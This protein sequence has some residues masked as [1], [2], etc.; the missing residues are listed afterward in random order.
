MKNFLQLLSLGI[1]LSIAI[2]WLNSNDNNVEETQNNL[3][4]VRYF[5]PNGNN[6]LQLSEM[7]SNLEYIPINFQDKTIGKVVTTDDRIFVSNFV[8]DNSLTIYDRK[9]E[10]LVK[11]NGSSGLNLALPVDF[12]VDEI[13]Q[14]I[15]I[16]DTEQKKIFKFDYEGRLVHEFNFGIHFSAFNYSTKEEKFILYVPMPFPGTDLDGNS[17]VIFDQNLNITNSHFPLHDLCQEF[18]P[19]VSNRFVTSG[20]KTYFNPPLT[21]TIYELFYDGTYSKVFDL[22]GYDSNE[23]ENSISDIIRSSDHIPSI[24]NEIRN[25][26]P[27]LSFIVSNKYVI[28]EKYFHSFPHFIILDKQT[29]RSI[30]SATRMK[31]ENYG[32]KF[33]FVFSRPRFYSD[34]GVISYYSNKNCNYFY[35]AISKIETDDN[36][37]ITLKNAIENDK[38]LMMVY[39]YNFDFL[40]DNSKEDLSELSPFS[41]GNNEHSFLKD[42]KVYPNPATENIKIE[43]KNEHKTADIQLISLTGTI[44][45]HKIIESQNGRFSTILE[46]QKLITGPYFIN[47]IT[48]DGQVHPQQIQINN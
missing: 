16:G 13:N 29:K 36:K 17:I 14:E 10:K 3:E 34:D 33:D 38:G 22:P 25:I 41:N 37:I 11:I 18:S 20:D 31:I 47:I 12:T 5:N 46:V 21:S 24:A 7:Y 40:F 30:I 26:Q 9:G 6:T 45:E 19:L 48:A 43:F 15:Y 44:I 35:N 23:L 8:G 42:L 27:I 39:Q 32:N 2:A 1:I 4:H 28:V